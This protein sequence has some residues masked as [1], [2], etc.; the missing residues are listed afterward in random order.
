MII[1]KDKIKL[2]PSVD[3]VLIEYEKL[4][5][6]KTAMEMFDILVEDIADKINIELQKRES[7]IQ[8][9]INAIIESLYTK[10]GKVKANAKYIF[11]NEPINWRNLG[12]INTKLKYVAY[13]SEASPT[14][15][16]FIEHVEQ[17]LEKKGYDLNNIEIILKWVK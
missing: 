9:D 6:K 11:K 14:C 15:W 3:R 2:I 17:E 4:Y 8:N 1:S 13:I 7:E 5:D 12:C 16:N 10:D